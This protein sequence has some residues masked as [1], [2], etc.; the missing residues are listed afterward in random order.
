MQE[1]DYGSKIKMIVAI[2]LVIRIMQFQDL[3]TSKF[4]NQKP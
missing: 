1:I 3:Q 2:K 4:A